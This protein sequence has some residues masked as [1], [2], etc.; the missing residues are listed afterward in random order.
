[1]LYGKNE[2]NRLFSHYHRL[3]YKT[4]IVGGQVWPRCHVSDITMDILVAGKGRGGMF[5]FVSSLLFLFLFLPCPLLSS[6]LLYLY[7]FSLGDNTK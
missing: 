5:L 6:P 7:L 3:C 2:T 1:M 4:C